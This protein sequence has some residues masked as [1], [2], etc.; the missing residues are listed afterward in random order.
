MEFIEDAKKRQACYSKRSRA[1]LKKAK[2]LSELTGV[3]VCLVVAPKESR[4]RSYISPTDR[5]LKAKR[6]GDVVSLAVKTFVPENPRPSKKP[7]LDEGLTFKEISEKKE[8]KEESLYNEWMLL[9]KYGGVPV[10]PRS[11]RKK[12]SSSFVDRKKNKNKK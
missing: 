7:P 1:L 2:E 12:P 4:A 5:M 9:E 3:T 8:R 11:K 10:R 6:R